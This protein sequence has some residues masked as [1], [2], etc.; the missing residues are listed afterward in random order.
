[1]TKTTYIIK[2][3]YFNKPSQSDEPINGLMTLSTVLKKLTIFAEKNKSI[4]VLDLYIEQTSQIK[5]LDDQSAIAVIKQEN[6]VYEIYFGSVSAYAQFKENIGRIF[7]QHYRK[8]YYSSGCLMYDGSVLET[9]SN[10][11]YSGKGKYYYDNPSKKLKY[12]GEFANCCYDGAGVFYSCNGNIK[13]MAN[14]ISKGIPTQKGILTFTFNDMSQNM[15]VVFNELWTKLNINPNDKKNI[16]NI[17]GAD[18]FVLKIAEIYWSKKYPTYPLDQKLFTEKCNQD[19]FVELWTNQATMLKNVQ[20]HHK[21]ITN[22]T[23]LVFAVF[24]VIVLF[25]CCLLF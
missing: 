5:L 10:V 15:P 19:K 24:I 8:Y 22:L 9:D 1:M 25:I 11:Q 20:L 4:P 16:K 12:E 2:F 14:N 7:N 21:T 23:H 3:S 18:D 13:L 6:G 17:V